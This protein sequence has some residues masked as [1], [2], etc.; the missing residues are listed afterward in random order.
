MNRLGLAIILLILTGLVIKF[1]MKSD[2]GLSSLAK[3]KCVCDI[4]S[5]WSP[6]YQKKIADII[7]DNY[8]K[9]NNT[10]NLIK[11]TVEEFKEIN[12]MKAEICG[13]DSICFHA[14]GL[15]PIFILDENRVVVDDGSIFERKNFDQA[16][17]ESLPK[18]TALKTDQVIQMVHFIELM[19]K[20]IINQYG[21]DWHDKNHIVL[22]SKKHEGMKCLVSN[23]L[24][25]SEKTFKECSL[26]YLLDFEKL[27]K[28]KQ[29]KHMVE[30]D[31]RF[32][33]QIIVRSGGN[34]G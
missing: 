5:N 13:I 27:P 33:N 16:V 12:A 19:P 1:W 21:I 9:N 29:K 28:K 26:L 20:D 11:Q 6:E 7:K 32:K 25:P 10:Q 24:I 23:I 4:D 18:I 14:H 22:Q 31:I 15:N 3:P 17:T 2:K 34:Y 8:K 30:Y